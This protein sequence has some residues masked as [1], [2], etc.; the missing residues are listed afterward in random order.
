M[1]YPPVLYPYSWAHV[2]TPPYLVDVVWDVGLGPVERVPKK[3]WYTNV[4][5]NS[6]PWYAYGTLK[7]TL[8]VPMVTD[9]VRISA[10]GGKNGQNSLSNLGSKP[11]TVFPVM[12][13]YT[14]TYTVRVHTIGTL[15]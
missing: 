6:V 9:C 13:H 7:D 10:H 4:H 15:Y 11:Y 2:G 12:V 14:R 1:Y 8:S 5:T 3:H